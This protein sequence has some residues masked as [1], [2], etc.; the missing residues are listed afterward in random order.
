[1]EVV[2]AKRIEIAGK[3]YKKQPTAVLGGSFVRDFL[4]PQVMYQGKT[5]HCLPKYNY[6]EEW[7]I[8]YSIN[9]WSNETT[10]KEYVDNIL[11]PYIT[12]KRRSLGLTDDHPALVFSII[13]RFRSPQTYLPSWIKT[14]L[15]NPFTA[16]T[17]LKD[18]VFAHALTK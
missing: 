8:T 4:P 10:M 6:P 12:E 13:L 5:P 1:M 11:V 9:H 3:N 17:G 18:P 16:V 7:H 2:G 15:I 14:I